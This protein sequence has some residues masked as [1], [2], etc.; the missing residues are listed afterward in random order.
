MEG[1]PMLSAQDNRPANPDPTP[2]TTEPLARWGRPLARAAAILYFVSWVFPIGGGLSKNTAALPKWWGVL[3]VGLAFVLAILV[4]VLA[5]L[6]QGKVDRRAE[7]AS[8]RAYR[9][10]IH[11][12][13]VFGLVFMLAGDR[14]TWVNCATG[15]SWRIWL[16]LYMLP[17]WFAALGYQ[18]VAKSS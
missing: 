14:I 18:G 10:L 9:I 16:L 12:L 3:D 2:R 4:I 6:T 1:H 15:F 5:A 7:D 13:L 11:G 17:A 8:Y